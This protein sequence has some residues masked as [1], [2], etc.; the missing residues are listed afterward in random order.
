MIHVDFLHSIVSFLAS[1]QASKAIFFSLKPTPQKEKKEKENG[2]LGV[3]A[4]AGAGAGAG[5]DAAL[6]VRSLC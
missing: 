4:G 5:A 3:K 2:S 6:P 1:K